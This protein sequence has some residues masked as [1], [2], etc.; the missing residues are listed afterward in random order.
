MSD[1]SF[2]EGSYYSK[3]NTCDN[4]SF[5]EAV[6]RRSSVK[7]VFFKF[8]QNLQENICARA[9]FSIKLQASAWGTGVFLWILRNL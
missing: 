8:S 9:S 2:K 4:E 5:Q 3:A 7:K 6:V 1:L